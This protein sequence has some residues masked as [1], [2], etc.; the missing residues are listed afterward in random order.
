MRTSQLASS[1]AGSDLR[2][3]CITYGT[4]SMDTSRS[5]TQHPD[6]DP[7]TAWTIAQSPRCVDAPLGRSTCTCSNRPQLTVYP[8]ELHAGALQRDSPLQ[9]S[10]SEVAGCGQVMPSVCSV[11]ADHVW[12]IAHALGGFMAETKRNSGLGFRFRV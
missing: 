9:I 7:R 8:R 4:G 5:R 3:M 12:S 10:L 11:L 6:H 2:C 1:K